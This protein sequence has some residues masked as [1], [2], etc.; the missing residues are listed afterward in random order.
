MVCDSL[1]KQVDAYGSTKLGTR[2]RNSCRIWN[3]TR[4]WLAKRSVLEKSEELVGGDSMCAAP[5]KFFN[6]KPYCDKC[7]KST[8]TQH[9]YLKEQMINEHGNLVN[10]W[11]GEDPVLICKKFHTIC[12]NC[13]VGSGTT[14]EGVFCTLCEPIF[15][16]VW[17]EKLNAYKEYREKLKNKSS[18]V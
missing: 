10:R 1:K 9:V 16:G 3:T 11:V 18:I 15:S 4:D 17:D 6:P 5:Q 13:L 14:E 8:F 7:S 2:S 12:P